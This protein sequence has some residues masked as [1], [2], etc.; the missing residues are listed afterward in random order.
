M[1]D[2]EQ[3]TG[4]M[5]HQILPDEIPDLPD[6]H[7][8]AF[9]RTAQ[10]ALTNVQK[11]AHAQQVWLVLSKSDDAVTLLVGDDGQG[12]SL[13]SEQTGFG[14]HGLR[15]RAGQLGGELHLEP[16]SGGGTQL[17]LRLPLPTGESDGRDDSHSA[18]G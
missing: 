7:R 3:A 14:L 12:L 5:V 9:Y 1:A 2:F 6:A 16:R 18:G 8:L 4:F 10:E 17:S 15:E 11:H 13:S